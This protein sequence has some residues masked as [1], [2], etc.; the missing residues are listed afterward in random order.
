M[1]FTLIGAAAIAAWNFSLP[2]FTKWAPHVAALT[3]AA[4]LSVPLPIP[5]FSEPAPPSTA[6]KNRTAGSFVAS[7]FSCVR[8]GQR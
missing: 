7:W 2:A 5:A 4:A 6:M 1:K 3:L 8:E